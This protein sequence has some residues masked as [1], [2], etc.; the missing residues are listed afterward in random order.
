M[1]DTP[2]CTTA[3]DSQLFTIYFSPGN[4]IVD[5][6]TAAT[7]NIMM[8]ALAAHPPVLLDGVQYDADYEYGLVALDAWARTLETTVTQKDNAN[9]VA[10]ARS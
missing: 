10:F 2:P 6:T 4:G 3:V 1:A 5:S 7:F 9:V 8:D